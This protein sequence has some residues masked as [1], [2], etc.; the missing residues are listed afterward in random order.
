MTH[1]S[2]GSIADEGAQGLTLTVGWPGYRQPS[3]PQNN[4]GPCRPCSPPPPLHR[5][6]RLRGGQGLGATT[7]TLPRLA[8]PLG[9]GRLPRGEEQSCAPHTH[10]HV[11]ACSQCTRIHTGSG[12]TLLWA[13]GQAIGQRGLPPPGRSSQQGPCW[14]ETRMWALVPKSP[15]HLCVAA[16]SAFGLSSEQVRPTLEDMPG[17]EE[18]KEPPQQRAH[19]RPQAPTCTLHTQAST[20]LADHGGRGQ[21]RAG[22]GLEPQGPRSPDGDHPFV[23]ASSHIDPHTPSTRCSPPHLCLSRRTQQRPE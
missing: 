2:P 6:E 8:L 4:P 1:S 22:V 5:G 18:G 16:P 21:S 20:S 14:E 12:L 11:C 17:P 19:G 13:P 9:A 3:A 15:V 23:M 7:D 10:T